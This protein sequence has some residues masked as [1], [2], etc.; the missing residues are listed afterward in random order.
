[1]LQ[2]NIH[3]MDIS[4]N[5]CCLAHSTITNNYN[6]ECIIKSVDQKPIIGSYRASLS[7]PHIDNVSVLCGTYIYLSDDAHTQD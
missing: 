6:F 3:T 7:E 2:Y 4:L 5:Q 1:M